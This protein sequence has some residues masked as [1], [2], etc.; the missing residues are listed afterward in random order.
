MGEWDRSHVLQPNQSEEYIE[1]I[2][3]W[4]VEEDHLRRVF[5]FVDFVEAFNFM[6]RVA[7]ISEELDHHPDWANSWN[8]VDITITNHQAGG[9]TEIDFVLCERINGLV[10]L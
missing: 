3:G 6:T 7:D 5:V 1:R 2:P 8:K 4:E 9:I 10:A